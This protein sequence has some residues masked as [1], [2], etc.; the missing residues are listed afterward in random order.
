MNHA[1]ILN[2]PV[3]LEDFVSI[4]QWFSHQLKDTV[5]ARVSMS[6]QLKVVLMY[7]QASQLTDWDHELFP[8]AYGLPLY[9]PT[10]HEKR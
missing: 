7:S 3:K 2:L 5:L 6:T 4:A 10:K 1:A 8:N 9:D